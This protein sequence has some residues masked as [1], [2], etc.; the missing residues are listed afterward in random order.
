M[1]WA[2][3]SEIPQ[4]R[5]NPVYIGT[6]FVF[7]FF[8][9]AAIYAKNSGILLAFRF[10][11]SGVSLADIYR[12]AKRAYAIGIW[13]ASRAT[14]VFLIVFLPKTSFADLLYRI[15]RHLRKHPRLYNLRSEPE[16]A[17]DGTSVSGI[18]V[19]AIVRPISLNFTESIIFFM[20]L[21]IILIYEGL[22]FLGIFVAGMTA[23]P[24]LFHWLYKMQEPQFNENGELKPEKR[25]PPALVGCFCIPVCLFSS[26]WTSRASTHWIVPIIGSG[27]FTIESFLPFNSVPNYLGGAHPEYDASVFA[28]TVC[29]EVVLELDSAL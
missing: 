2:P 21:Y 18:A 24:C 3:L 1:T 12:P 20:N 29:S 19:I 10:L 13:V 26:A 23:A 4:M 22:A 5:R 15:T 11:T 17:R 8:Q 6:L 16:P 27:F 14:L 9:F 7:V 25:L 28:A